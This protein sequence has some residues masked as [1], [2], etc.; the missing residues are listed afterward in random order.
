MGLT[1]YGLMK[2]YLSKYILYKLSDD[3]ND[4]WRI[5]FINEATINYVQDKKFIILK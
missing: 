5:V 4:Y 2:V 3:T 1:P